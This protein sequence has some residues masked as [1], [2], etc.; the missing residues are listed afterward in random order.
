MRDPVGQWS[1]L[2][3][4]IHLVFLL[5]ST[6]RD[7]CRRLI[8]RVSHSSSGISTIREQRFQGKRYIVSLG[9]MNPSHSN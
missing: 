9:D 6:V 7:L 2:R 3:V 8:H 1:I 4:I 5:H